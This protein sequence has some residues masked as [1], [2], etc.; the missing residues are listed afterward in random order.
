MEVLQNIVLK[1]EPEQILKRLHVAENNQH[2]NKILRELLEISYQRVKPKAVYEVSYVDNKSEDCL[3]IAGVRFTSRVL[4]VNLDTVERVFPFIVTCGKELDRIAV[5]A[6]DLMRN[7]CLDAIKEEFLRSA[8][9]YLKDYVK[10][11]YALP[12]L[13]M[14]NPGSLEDWSI[15]QQ[16]ELFSIFSNVEALIGVRLTESS[17]MIPVKSVSGILF[18]T[19]IAFES[20]QL[21][22]R[23]S[24]V[25]RRAPYDPDLAKIYRQPR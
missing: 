20:C 21:C 15:T 8:L 24:C 11:R 12:Q 9:E 6:N 7:F 14:M 10:R 22:P 17:I 25:E 5:A 2:M 13:S 16:R 23:E 1:V 18:P 4:R 3:N 19:E